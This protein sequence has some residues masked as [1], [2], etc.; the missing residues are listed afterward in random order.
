MNPD[1]YD[2]N[3]PCV[4]CGGAVARDS[5][6]V[7]VCLTCDARVRHPCI[8]GCGA[9][10]DCDGCGRCKAECRNALA[11]D[12]APRCQVFDMDE[13]PDAPARCRHGCGEA[14]REEVAAL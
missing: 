9:P 8:D 2:P 5:A 4:E 3:G 1:R 14:P 12:G 11:Q 13:W 10:G 7:L 6:G